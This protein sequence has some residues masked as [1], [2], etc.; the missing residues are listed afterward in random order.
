MRPKSNMRRDDDRQ[1]D[2]NKF[3]NATEKVRHII[4]ILK[5]LEPAI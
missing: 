2:T 4:S 5:Q 3:I 1:T